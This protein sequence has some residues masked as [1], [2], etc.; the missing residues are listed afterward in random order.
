MLQDG[1]SK[2]GLMIYIN[3]N[4]GLILCFSPIKEIIHGWN[5]KISY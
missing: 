1:P 2:A 4:V 3:E 5:I